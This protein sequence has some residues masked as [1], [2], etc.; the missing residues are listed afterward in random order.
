MKTKLLAGALLLILL[1]VLG[2]KKDFVNKSGNLPDPE[3]YELKA[4]N[5]DPTFTYSYDESKYVGASTGGNNEDDFDTYLDL[6]PGGRSS[7]TMT[8]I[9]YPPPG[10]ARTGD[11]LAITIKSEKYDPW[12]FDNNYNTTYIA[13]IPYTS[14]YAQVSYWDD[15][16]EIDYIS[17]NRPENMS[18]QVILKR[19]G[20]LLHGE[21]KSLTLVDNSGNRSFTINDLRFQVRP[22]DNP[23]I[24]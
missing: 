5:N 22:S 19:I 1:Q 13:Q 9:L 23:L 16:N 21:I 18:K 17:S 11:A 15:A 4:N 14:R 8:V 7:N 24:D 10:H 6:I 20:N 2:C 12:T 3:Q